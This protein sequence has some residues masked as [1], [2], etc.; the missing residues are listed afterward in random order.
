MGLEESCK[1]HQMSMKRPGTKPLHNVLYFEI[2][3]KTKKL[4]WGFWS[5]L[6][7]WKTGKTKKKDNDIRNQKLLSKDLY[8]NFLKERQNLFKEYLKTAQK[9]YETYLKDAHNKMHERGYKYVH[10]LGNE[11]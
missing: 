8:T 9:L 11:D 7:T 3:N 2:K 4:D 10:L 6:N 5:L 1:F